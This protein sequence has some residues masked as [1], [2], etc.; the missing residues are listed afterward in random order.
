MTGFIFIFVSSAL[1]ALA[2]NYGNLLLLSSSSS[3]TMIFNLLMA[4]YFLKEFFN[5]IYDTIAIFLIIVGSGM[6]LA[7][8]KNSGNDTVITNK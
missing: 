5:W 1:N 2:L 3:I 8:S 4:R 7:F 6:C